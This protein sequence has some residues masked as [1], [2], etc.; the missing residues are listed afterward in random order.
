MKLSSKL[1][2]ALLGATAILAVAATSAK[3]EDLVIYDAVDFTG[4]VA[5]AFTAKTGINVRGCVKTFGCDR[6]FL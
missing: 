3:A 6:M 2:S 5:K 1:V 4:A